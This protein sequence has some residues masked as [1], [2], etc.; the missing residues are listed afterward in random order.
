MRN[1]VYT[2]AQLNADRF[3]RLKRTYCLGC[4]STQGKSDIAK[5][6]VGGPEENPRGIQP[7]KDSKR[8]YLPEERKGGLTL[9]ALV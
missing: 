4:M 2:H 7:Y 3:L 9:K 5:T 6:C 1:Y 8:P